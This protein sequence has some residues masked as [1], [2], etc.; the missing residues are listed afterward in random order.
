MFFIL[1]ILFLNF[2]TQSSAQNFV[3]HND[4]IY[5][6]D[7]YIKYNGLA[8]RK[9]KYIKYDTEFKIMKYPY[10]KSDND[11]LLGG[12]TILLIRKK[13]ND[14]CFMD[15]NNKKLKCDKNKPTYSNL[16][17]LDKHGEDHKPLYNNQLIKIRMTNNSID[18]SST[19]IE[20]LSCY[21]KQKIQ[22]YYSYVVYK[23]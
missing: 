1:S 14:F 17:I 13:N 11:Y 22:K 23:L 15:Y 20:P 4:T 8:Y 7:I 21:K 9:D 6:H 2:L 10:Y 18:C 19:T 5:I 3:K 16:R 12:M